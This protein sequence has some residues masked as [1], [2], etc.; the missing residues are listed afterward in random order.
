MTDAMQLDEQ[1]QA[2][3]LASLEPIA[4]YLEGIGYRMVENIGSAFSDLFSVARGQLEEEQ[5]GFG[6]GAEGIG[7]Q[8]FDMSS[9][10]FLSL[11]NGPQYQNML[12][13]LQQ[14]GYEPDYK[15]M[16]PVLKDGILEP[17]SKD[18]KIV[19]A[20]RNSCF[21]KQRFRI[22]HRFAIVQVLKILSFMIVKYP[23]SQ[24]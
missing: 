18:W 15:T 6:Q 10:A 1:Q 17:M 14:K 3:F 22:Y 21:L 13:S 2:L 4:I 7:F 20:L 5:P 23:I 24:L 16:I 9:S 19:Q 11:V 8:T 12:Q